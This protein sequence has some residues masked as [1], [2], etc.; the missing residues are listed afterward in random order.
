M[1]RMAQ[2]GLT[3]NILVNG[4]NI[5]DF[6]QLAEPLAFYLNLPRAS[7]ITQGL[8]L[9]NDSTNSFSTTTGATANSIRKVYNAAQTA[10]QIA[11]SAAETQWGDY[12]NNIFY[13]AGSVGIGVSE[14]DVSFQLYVDGNAR[15]D[16]IT[17]NTYIGLPT[18]TTTSLGIV[19]L[20]DDVYNNSTTIAPTANALNRVY[21]IASQTQN[22]LSSVFGGGDLSTGFRELSVNTI[23]A[24]VYLGIPTSSTRIVGLVRLSDATASQDSTRAASSLAVKQL[25]DK[26]NVLTTLW[27]ASSFAGVIQTYQNID[28]DIDVGNLR[29]NS[30]YC[31]NYVNLPLA[32][33]SKP[34]IVMLSDSLVNDDST[35]A[36]TSSAIKQLNDKVLLFS[37]QWVTTQD[38]G[39]YYEKSVGIG[40]YPINECSLNVYGDIRVGGRIKVGEGNFLNGLR[41]Y[42]ITLPPTNAMPLTH[43]LTFETPC[44]NTNYQVFL[45][46]RSTETKVLSCVVTFKSVD[47]LSFNVYS[48]DH[49]LNVY[50]PTLLP[51]Y[52]D[53]LV[54]L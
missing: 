49:L 15:C 54:M 43:T 53:T 29:C 3:N 51:V 20:T 38:E 7:T 36:A 22:T 48:L 47:F 24:A 23:R 14:Y 35:Q 44:A 27:N 28:F 4:V 13:D 2:L 45:T 6:Y 8:V 40:T 34:G 41:S 37:G 11:Q 42:T 30:L 33:T 31:S 19:K 26:I 39:I 50:S 46:P 18:S 21:N 16:S 12:A 17:S 10:I 5:A 52:V 1:S 9:L 32:S 25:N